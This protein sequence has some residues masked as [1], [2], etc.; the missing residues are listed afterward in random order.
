RRRRAVGLVV[1]REVV[2]VETVVLHQVVEDAERDEPARRLREAVQQKRV[3][4]V[5]DRRSLC[6]L[7]A[8]LDRRLVERA[9]KA[10]DG[11]AEQ[12]GPCAFVVRGPGIVDGDRKLI[13][14]A[15]V[16][17]DTPRV[18][19]QRLDQRF[20][21]VSSDGFVRQD[22]VRRLRLR[23]E[24]RERGEARQNETKRARATRGGRKLHVFL[25]VPGVA[26]CAWPYG[27]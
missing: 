27:S 3:G 22:L 6:F 15:R 18:A 12:E 9:V 19:A 1:F 4:R 2:D 20:A 7:R 10:V 17:C 14:D 5:A 8:A 25:P 23:G 26:C 11:L 13:D 21:P 16:V 24:A